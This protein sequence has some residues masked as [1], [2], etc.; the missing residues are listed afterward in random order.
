MNS[1]DPESK[2][3]KLPTWQYLCI[4]AAGIIVIAFLII[5]TVNKPSEKVAQNVTTEKPA[6][7]AE[8]SAGSE[9]NISPDEEEYN[10]PEVVSYDE[11]NGI[12]SGEYENVS[13]LYKETPFFAID[14]D[15]YAYCDSDNSKSLMFMTYRDFKTKFKDEILQEKIIENYMYSALDVTTAD[16][17]YTFMD[18]SESDDE[19]NFK[20]YRI[21]TKSDKLS[22]GRGIKVGQKVSDLYAILPESD[23]PDGYSYDDAS[24][25]YLFDNSCAPFAE[26]PDFGNIIY[27]ATE[28]GDS[29]KLVMGF[30]CDESSGMLHITHNDGVITDIVAIYS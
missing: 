27:V 5:F 15:W 23:I 3:I 11:W 14:S 22:F 24:V 16:A 9:E 28:D 10:P 20:L 13:D 1:K 6:A 29:I 30:Y 7:S 25:K 8:I 2:R 21:S 18:I 26:E 4:S 17:I 19:E 12:S